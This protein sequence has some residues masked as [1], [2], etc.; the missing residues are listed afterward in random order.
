MRVSREPRAAQR[1]KYVRFQQLV[2]ERIEGALRCV[3]AENK[4]M[5]VVP[6]EA[7]GATVL[8]LFA[9]Q[10]LDGR[11]VCSECVAQHKLP[12]FGVA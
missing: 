12:V 8:L 1:V 9:H 11:M 2:R 6:L 4:H 7:N 10:S 5:Q 3:C